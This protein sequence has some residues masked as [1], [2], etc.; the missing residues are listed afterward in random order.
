[1]SLNICPKPAAGAISIMLLLASIGHSQE[2]GSAGKKTPEEA[3]LFEKIPLVEAASMHLQT[4]QEA[5]ANVTVITDEDIRTYGYRTFGEALSS[6]RGFWMTYDHA[7]YQV[8]VRGFGVPGDYNSRFLVMINGHYLTDNVY[9]ASYFFGPDFGLDLELVKRI[10][11][12]RGPSS[13]LYGSNG[14]FATIN[15]VTK[16]PVEGQHASVVA[17]A[18]SF[19]AKRLFVSSATAMGSRGHLLL[20]ASGYG[21]KGQSLYFPEYDSPSTNQGRAVGVDGAIAYHTFANLTW[22]AWSLTAYVNSRDK[23]MPLGYGSTVFNDKATNSRDGRN[24][25]EAAYSRDV[26]KTG[27]LRWRLYYDQIRY[28]ARYDY[29]LDNGVADNRDLA[30]GDWV[31]SRFSYRFATRFGALT[32]GTETNLDLRTL[33]WNYDVSPAFVQ[34][35]KINTPNRSFGLFV[36]QERELS[37]HWKAWLGLRFDGSTNHGSFVS[38]RIGLVYQPSPHTTYKFLYRRAFRNPNALEQFY[39]DGGRS[40]IANPQLQPEHA[41]TFEVVMERRLGRRWQSVASLYHYWLSNLVVPQ[42]TENALVQY[43]NMSQMRATGL[44]LELS[45]Q[46]A[47]WLETTTSWAIQK[48]FQEGD[49]NFLANSPHQ[50]GKL[51]A[52]IPL[53]TRKVYLAGALQYLGERRT[54]RQAPLEP[55]ALADLTLTTRQ[56]HRSFDLTVGIRNLADC[57]YW[58]PLAIDEAVDRIQGT[59]RTA[60]VKLIWHT[61]E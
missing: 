1:M 49:G 53:G 15:V 7:D 2:S 38:P 45:G 61:P 44:E 19:G 11:I 20:A 26:G 37:A 60:F 54:L 3:I 56:L 9:N 57:R 28:R 48:P 21:D 33:Q 34:Y 36:Q 12:I 24:F 17:E 4:L 6:V 43:R 52:A 51:R 41:H 40:D 47:E 31:G 59:G 39:D 10:E 55:V 5:P 29:A 14:V 30:L 32:L 35:I 58:D 23:R 16:A 50:V 13:A 22:G 42:W 18:G 25:V 27:Q 8:G 46:P